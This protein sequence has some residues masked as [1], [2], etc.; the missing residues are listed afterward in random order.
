MKMLG[1]VGLVL[2]VFLM[3]CSSTQ[4]DWQ[5]ATAANTV[6]S[7]Q[8]FLKEHPNGQHADEARTRIH[9]LRDNQAWMAA[10]NTNTEAGFKKYVAGEPHGAHI[11]D[12]KEK[13]VGFQ[14]ATAWQAASQKGTVTALKAFVAKYPNGPE[15]DQARAELKKLLGYQAQVG[16]AYRSA[17]YAMRIAQHLKARFGNVLHN[18]EVVAPMGHSRYHHLR[19]ARMSRKEAEMACAKLHRARERCEVVKAAS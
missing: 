17:K 13:I 6:A 14:R 1:V 15:S 5:K 19:S 11:A 18:V 3:A 10:M 16:G 7:Y 4:A 12:A 8:D 2:A 9:H